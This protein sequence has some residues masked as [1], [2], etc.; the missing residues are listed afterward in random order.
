MPMPDPLPESERAAVALVVVGSGDAI[1]PCPVC[2]TPLRGRQT[3]ACSDRCRAAKSRRQRS[4]AQKHRDRRLRELLEAAV[5]ILARGDE[6]R[7]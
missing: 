1:R 5:R 6:P 3:S 4:D 2:G 7:T